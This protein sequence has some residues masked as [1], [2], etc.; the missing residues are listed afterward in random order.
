MSST[1]TAPDVAPAPYS[2]YGAAAAMWADHAPEVVIEGPA[3]TGKSRAA[4]EKLDYCARKYDGMRGLIVRKTR[5]SMTESVLVTWEQKVLGPDSPIVVPGPTRASRQRYLYPNGSEVVV[6]GLV[7]NSRD[8]RAKIMSTE[9]DLIVVPEATELTEDDWDKL[10]TRLRNGVMPYQQIL[11]DCNPDAPTHWLHRRCDRGAAV[12]YFSRHADNPAVTPEYLARLGA[13]TGVR[14]ER[15]FRGKRAAA[16]GAVYEFDRAVHLRD[17]FP[18]PAGWSRFRSFD[19]GFT[20]PFVCQWWALDPDG[21]MYLYRELYASQRTVKVHAERIK[22][23]EQWFMPDGKTP[24]PAR[25]RFEA[26]VADTDAEDRATLDENGIPTIPADKDISPGIQAV[27]E[28][29]KVRGDGKP[30]LFILRGALAERDEALAEASLPVCTEQEF[31]AYVWPKGVDGKPIKEKPV[32]LYNHGMDALRYAV[33][34]ADARQRVGSY[35][36]LPAPRHPRPTVGGG[37]TG[38]FRKGPSFI[39]RR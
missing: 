24:N 39:G 15:L 28:R 36:P 10:S 33:R 18:I 11:G 30:R 23:L 6:G 1:P 26:S 32:D 3:G 29:L 2:A 5:E 37:P 7:A 4:L 13:L 9:Y 12:C 8:Q 35:A 25:E 21:R 17:P 19:F 20:N 16:E 22:V 38:Q 34:W 27:E 14:R 31:D